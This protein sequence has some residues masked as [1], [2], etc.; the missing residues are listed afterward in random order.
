MPDRKKNT[1]NRQKDKKLSRYWVGL[2]FLGPAVFFVYYILFAGGSGTS[3]PN[4]AYIPPQYREAGAAVAVDRGTLTAA[5]GGR[6]IYSQKLVMGHNTIVP[7]GGNIFAVVP[8]SAPEVFEEP[9]SAQWYIADSDGTKYD[10][11]KTVKNNPAG[12]DIT[13]G[14]KQES[15]VFYLI[16]KISKKQKDLYLVYSSP[17]P[18][19][20]WKLP[21]YKGEL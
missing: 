14:I 2:L 7:E 13:E 4:K 19:A 21:P 3:P 16:F 12:S 6:V 8:L 9:G 5:P 17:S 10:L 15:Q 1:K 18:P 11:L 20:A